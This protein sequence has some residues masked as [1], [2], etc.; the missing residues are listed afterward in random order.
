MN[1]FL[2]VEGQLENVQGMTELENH[3][4]ATTRNLTD[5]GETP[6]RMQE[7]AGESGRGNRVFSLHVS[8]MKD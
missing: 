5:S 7:L 4:L 1:K 8:L 6:G 3:H 2:T